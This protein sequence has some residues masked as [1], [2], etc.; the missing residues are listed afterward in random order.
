MTLYDDF[1]EGDCMKKDNEEKKT[2]ANKIVL[3]T[4]TIIGFA[5]GFLFY[6]RTEDWMVF[7]VF[8]VFAMVE[9]FVVRTVFESGINKLAI[10][11]TNEMQKIKDGDFSVLI[12]PKE[13]GILGQV[14][15]TVNTVLSDI[16]KL[17]DGFF[18][19]SLAINSSSYTVKNVS[20]NATDAIQLISQTTDDI[21]KGATSQAE[22]AQNGVLSV[23]KLADQINAVYNSS[24]EIIIETDRITQV[25]TAGV[26]AVESLKEKTV[27]NIN[28][29]EKII[30]VIEKLIQTVQ[31]ITSFTDS[32]ENIT[33]QTNMLALNAAIEAARAG[34]AGL[35]FAVVADEVRRLADQSRQANLEITNLVESISDDSQ[36]AVSVMED[37]RNASEEQNLSVEQTGQA[38][39]D[40]ANAIYAIVDKFRNVNESVNKMQTDKD[41][42]IKS[43]EHISSV[44]QETAAASEEMAATTDSQ[45]NAFDELQQASTD[46]EQLVIKLDENLKRYKLR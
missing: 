43:I 1:L 42:V 31:Q 6:M 19:L 25:N 15:T 30:L 13:Y 35:G 37:L 17:I 38:F 14:A 16:K 11:F 46:L 34:E 41:E 8:G 28:A 44:S 40:I 10:R 3:I 9:A 5:I 20:K 21:S 12:V 7:I 36:M 45:M 22:E 23:E 24:N 39:S 27:M 4:A 26:N 29:S 33:E 18:Q 32:I 2:S